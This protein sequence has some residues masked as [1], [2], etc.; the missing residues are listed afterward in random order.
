MLYIDP[1]KDKEFKEKIGPI[2][3]SKVLTYLGSKPSKSEVN[4]II[5]V[6]IL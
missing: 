2:D 5:W 3:L 6:F 1:K 4:L